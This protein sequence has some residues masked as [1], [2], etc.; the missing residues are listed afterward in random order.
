MKAFTAKM[1]IVDPL[2]KSGYI[3]F[4]YRNS[5]IDIQ[6]RV[7]RSMA[8]IR[9]GVFTLP[10]NFNGAEIELRYDAHKSLTRKVGVY[11]ALRLVAPEDIPY[12][13]KGLIRDEMISPDI[14][15]HTRVIMTPEF[16]DATLTLI[17]LS[18]NV[19][20]YKVDSSDDS[21]S[22]TISIF[23]VNDLKARLKNM[24]DRA[25]KKCDTQV[26]SIS[27]STYGLRHLIQMKFAMK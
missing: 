11:Y 13:T 22:F 6:E 12:I 14:A 4:V 10:L 17:R 15:V 27:D 25:L 19:P 16:Q 20:V 7:Y 24:M 8:G 1:L 23:G 26:T 21:I 3:R 5:Y 9:G 2:N 18:F